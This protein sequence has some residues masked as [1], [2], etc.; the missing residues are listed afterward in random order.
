M[1]CVH[2]AV[3]L[4]GGANSRYPTPKAFIKLNGR[5]IIEC[6]LELLSK[7]FASL[8]I[9]TNTPEAYCKF[10]LPMIG[11]LLGCQ[12]PMSGLHACLKFLREG[13]ALFVACDMP[14]VK[15]EVIDLIC[16]FHREEFAATIP[17][18]HGRAQPLLAVYSTR[19]LPALE[20]ALCTDRLQLQ[21]FLIET[22]AV[23]IAEEEIKKIDAQGLSFVN[24]NTVADYAEA[25]KQ[26][27][28]TGFADRCG[29]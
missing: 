8:I 10:G 24:I 22:G 7:R 28:N 29:S 1:S 6:L 21:R 12:G 13:S 14:F 19:L 23:Y 20:H 9:S 11:D 3:L 18:F 5:M 4:A 15:A 17:V 2:A 27:G 26:Y 25:V 16:D